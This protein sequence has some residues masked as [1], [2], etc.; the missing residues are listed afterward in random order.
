MTDRKWSL[1]NS[2][3]WSMSHPRWSSQNSYSPPTLGGCGASWWDTG[4]DSHI[5]SKNDTY[6]YC[7][8]RRN[9]HFACHDLGNFCMSGDSN[10]HSMPESQWAIL[11]PKSHNPSAIAKVRNETRFHHRLR[12]NHH[13]LRLP[14]HL[15]CP[16][17]N[18]KNK[19]RTLMW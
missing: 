16:L 19:K 1:G 11:S 8:H 18:R 9:V 7:S 17:D 6:Y 12:P 15:R 5:N 10:P 3:W 14:H 2:T 13:R 4:T